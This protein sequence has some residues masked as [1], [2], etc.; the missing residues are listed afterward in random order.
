MTESTASCGIYRVLNCL[1]GDT[2]IG[3]SINIEKRVYCHGVGKKRCPHLSYEVLEVCREDE[4][5][6]KEWE[7][8]FRL[9]PSKNRKLPVLTPNLDQSECC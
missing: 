3:Q 6:G 9:R 8:V 7:W 5:D 2:Y 1:N 4:L